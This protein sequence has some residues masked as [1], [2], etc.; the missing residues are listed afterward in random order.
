MAEPA[1]QDY[2]AADQQDAQVALEQAVALLS[3]EQTLFSGHHQSVVDLA[4]AFYQ[5]LRARESLTPARLVITVGE[6]TAQ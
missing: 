6:I 2:L 3:N 4:E 1:T 5:F